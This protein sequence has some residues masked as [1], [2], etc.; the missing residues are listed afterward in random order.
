M[1]TLRPRRSLPLAMGLPALALS[2]PVLAA[3]AWVVAPI[4]ATAAGLT[5]ATAAMLTMLGAAAWVAYQRTEII[6]SSHGIVERGFLGRL[7]STAR[8]DIAAVIR[9]ETYRGDSLETAHQL[10]AV[11]HDGRCI[12][13]M[14]GAFWD[15]ASQALVADALD[16]PEVVRNEPVT[17]SE[18]RRS[19]PDLLY[20]FEGRRLGG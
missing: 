8:R 17:T 15:E 1:H 14:R 2:A 9:L 4:G 5:L 7:T 18:L 12:L 3:L 10:F 19:D 20:W 13:R 11:D 6:V 16:V